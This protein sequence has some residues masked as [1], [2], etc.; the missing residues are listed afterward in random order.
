MKLTI[1]CTTRPFKDL[2]FPEAC[3]C[4]AAAGYTDV[5][6]FSDVG[7]AADSSYKEILE[8]R[9]VAEDSGLTPSMLLAHAQPE[10]ADGEKN[11]LRLIDHAA[12]LGAS[13]I[14]DLGT[15]ERALLDSYI[16]MIQT[17]A[18]HAQDAGMQISAKP[19][20]GITTTTDD[21]FGVF[22]RVNHPAYGICYDPG[23]IIYYTKGAEMP[24]TNLNKIAP[25][26]ST[27]IIK[28]CILRDGKPCSLPVI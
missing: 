9:E 3:L 28:D 26:V 10:K 2:P 4:I 11:Y 19:H 21:L 5:A 15:G 27:C 6:I 18:S 24:E 23:N 17:A 1:G 16:S 20:G 22:Q 25:L 14:L 12:T 13:W 7:L 8:V